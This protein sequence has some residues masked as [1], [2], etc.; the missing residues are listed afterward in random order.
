[1]RIK[2]ANLNNLAVTL[3][4]SASA[5]A[6]MCNFAHISTRYRTICLVINILS[7]LLCLLGNSRKEDGFHITKFPFGYLAYVT[8]VVFGSILLC[9]SD[10]DLFRYLQVV[11]I[12]A[13]VIISEFDIETVLRYLTIFSVLLV[14]FYNNWFAVYY[15]DMN[16]A[17]MGMMYVV[18]NYII[19]GLI[20][21]VFYRR[22]SN[23]L[24][25]IGYISCLIL[26]IGVFTVGNRGA[27]LVVML[28][29][30]FC[31]L[32]TEGFAEEKISRKKRVLVIIAAILSILIYVNFDSIIIWLYSL[33]SKFFK[34]IPSF[35]VKMNRF[36]LAGDV[37]NGRTE[38]YEIAFEIIRDSPLFGI[39]IENFGRYYS[40][41]YPHNFILQ[42]WLEGGIL[43]AIVPTIIL[44]QYLC[45]V[46]WKKNQDV[47]VIASN[48]FFL[49][50]LI[51]FLISLDIWTFSEF[52]LS[53]FF[54]VSRIKTVMRNKP[55]KIKQEIQ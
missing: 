34:T 47:D 9:N 4:I 37:S 40:V 19:A 5:I 7:T 16:Q 14:P 8:V 45:N 6:Y 31:V 1:M 30:V 2:K 15:G 24:V 43:F 3:Y 13:T 12:G 10:Y 55:L 17:N 32:N 35:I 26:L 27:F 11:L 29:V 48:L 28:T 39:G 53:I 41:N 23:K 20:H 22:M 46:L 44:C 38:P 42:L 33:A 36:V 21:F 18:I 49:C 25:C 52:W 50:L 54:A 51:R